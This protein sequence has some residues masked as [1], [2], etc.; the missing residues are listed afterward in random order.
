MKQKI[1]LNKKTNMLFFSI[2]HKIFLFALLISQFLYF[3]ISELFPEGLSLNFVLKDEE[4]NQ[5]QG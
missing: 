5:V 1:Y 2:K 3:P 4:I